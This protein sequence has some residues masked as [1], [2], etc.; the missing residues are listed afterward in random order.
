MPGLGQPAGGLDPAEALRDALAQTLAGGVARMPGDRGGRQHVA[1]PVRRRGE[2]LR[3]QV[4]R[5]GSQRLPKPAGRWNVEP[6][7]RVPTVNRR[8]GTGKHA[9]GRRRLQRT[10][11]VPRSPFGRRH[12]TLWRDSLSN[13]RRDARRPRVTS[14]AGSGKMESVGVSPEHRLRDIEAERCDQAKKLV[15]SKPLA[16]ATMP[17]GKRRPEGRRRNLVLDVL[18]VFTFDIGAGVP[19]HETPAGIRGAAESFEWLTLCRQRNAAS[20]WAAY[21]ECTR[22]PSCSFDGVCTP[23]ATAFASMSASFPVAP[24]WFLREDAR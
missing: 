3:R 1:T 16:K 10:A 5:G 2:S 11:R 21:V 23:L 18:V 7:A 9:P 12:R 19:Q 15:A 8:E 22:S 24:I 4:P 14:R 17:E 13:G 20:S 6:E